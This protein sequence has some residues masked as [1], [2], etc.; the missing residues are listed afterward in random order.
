MVHGH[1]IAEALYKIFDR[2]RVTVVHD[3]TPRLQS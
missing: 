2:D 1:E 3:A